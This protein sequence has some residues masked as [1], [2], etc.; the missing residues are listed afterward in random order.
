MRRLRLVL[1]IASLGATQAQ[2]GIFDDEEARRQLTDFRIKTEA[3]FDQQAKA[4][5]E[6]SAQIQRQADEIARLRGLLETLG[7][8]QEVGDKRTQDFYLD[9]DSRLRKFETPVAAAPTPDST[10]TPAA[11]IK[12]DPAKESQDYEGALNQFKAAKYK[13]AA[14]AFAAFVQ[15][16]PDSSLAPNA[17][18]WLGNAWYAQR[19]CKRAIEAQSIVTTKYPDSAKA[20]DAWLAIATCQQELGNPTGV[21]RSLETVIAKYPN[22]PAA[23]SAQQ[24]LKKK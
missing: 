18:Y 20:S 15:K 6:L 21:K 9:L 16:Y 13:E 5:L 17:Q 11:A 24:R 14:A 8:K 7:Y 1:L 3:R 23:E 10:N 19:D 2:A 4:Q 22:T 12:G